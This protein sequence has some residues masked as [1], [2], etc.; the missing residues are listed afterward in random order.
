MTEPGKNGKRGYSWPPFTKGHKRGVIHGA[1][2][3]RRVRELAE[4][5]T[6]KLL[7]DPS[8]PAYLQEPSF[9]GAVDAHSRTAVIVDLLWAYVVD[10]DIAAAMADVTSTTEDEER[11]YEPGNGRRGRQRRTRRLSESH[12]VVSALRQLDRYEAT[13]AMQRTRLG[14]DPYGRAKLGRTMKDSASVTG[15]IEELGRQMGDDP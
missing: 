7:A 8:T 9:R 15:A 10:K 13:A 14:L 1:R 12:H 3:E 6:A 11:V 2:D 4:E 5:Y